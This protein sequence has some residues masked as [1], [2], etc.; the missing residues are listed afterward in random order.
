MPT[1]NVNPSVRRE[2][3]FARAKS[4]AQA[5]IRAVWH[6]IATFA[7][8]LIAVNRTFTAMFA[9]AVAYWDKVVP[10]F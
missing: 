10:A 4:L 9:D 1:Q 5:L 8:I 7:S 3:P 6:L 2:A